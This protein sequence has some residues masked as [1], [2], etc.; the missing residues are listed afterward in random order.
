MPFK[1]YSTQCVCVCTHTLTAFRHRLFIEES[2]INQ[3][4][5]TIE[6]PALRINIIHTHAPLQT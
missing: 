3:T 6:S 4:I 5:K 2:T 1:Y